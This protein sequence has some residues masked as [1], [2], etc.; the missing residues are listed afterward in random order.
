VTKRRHKESAKGTMIVL[1]IIALGAVAKFVVDYWPFFLILAIAC[2][3]YF[4]YRSARNPVRNH[5]RNAPAP[6]GVILS[7]FTDASH[8]GVPTISNG[9]GARSVLSNPVVASSHDVGSDEL[10]TFVSS[11]PTHASE[12]FSIPPAPAE[13]RTT[14]WVNISETLQIS[15]IQIS[16]A[17]LYVGPDLAA[18]SGR[19]DPALIDPRKP[20][21]GTG[22]YTERLTNY[23]PSYS[24]ISPHARR[25]YLEW[26]AEGRRAPD[27]DIGYVFLYF[28][29][30]EHRIIL[31]ILKDE[32]GLEEV[33]DIYDELKRLYAIYAEKSGSFKRYCGQLIEM[34]EVAASRSKL[35]EKPL[36]V[37]PSAW[38]FP[39][40]VRL[41]VGQAV[42]DGIPI[43]A[44]LALVWVEHDPAIVR[45]TAVTRCAAEFKKLFVSSY[46]AMYGDGLKITPNKTRLKLNY[47]PASSGFHGSGGVDLH[48]DDVPDIAALT[49]PSK[50]LQAL[51]DSCATLL[52]PYSR[53]L[54]KN[55]AG[56]SEL[57]GVLNLPVQLWPEAA[58]S[59][60]TVIKD[61]VGNSFLILTMTDLLATFKSTSS[62]G[63]GLQQAL[64]RVLEL[65]GIGMEPDL[66]GAMRANGSGDFVVLF[67]SATP[68]SEIRDIPAYKV[69]KLSVELA[70]AVAHA[71]GDFS[72]GELYHLNGC[73][74]RWEHLSDCARGRLK[75]YTR[76]LRASSI[77]LSSMRKN[78]ETLD[79]QSRESIAAFAATMVMADGGATPDEVKL[80]E[81][82]Y[83]QLGLERANLYSHIHSTQTP[84]SPAESIAGRTSGSEREAFSLDTAKIAMLKAS[85]DQIA[86]RLAA[87]F[88]DEIEPPPLP[89]DA[90]ADSVSTNTVLGLDEA[91]SA[92]ARV[93]M[94][95][96]TW[97]RSEMLDVAQDLEIMLDG[98]L[99]RL[100]ESCLDELDITFTEGDD[101]VHINP[102][103]MEKL[104]Q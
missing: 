7:G 67:K 5:P 102:D 44:N 54:A 77:G 15:G 93:L 103:L 59:A 62:L 31:D 72:K 53:Y 23:W 91:H 34:L 87:I 61:R 50:K 16:G 38:G 24:E 74:D 55:P 100:N 66:S 39:F 27:A 37:F 41:A 49:S 32:V 56:R 12:G 4:V 1:L 57:D 85:S 21:A 70:A 51:V 33:P 52:D 28:Y 19:T 94:S 101:P 82:I 84:K 13:L 65:E 2:A 30:L 63:K 78:L 60:L 104:T 83:Q 96:P 45:R 79:H 40:L 86:E 17:F 97:Q 80:L 47:E 8:V 76:L 18:P 90:Q 69:A 20:V 42:K 99:E 92:F 11:T 98:A 36:A 3:V 29:G 43:P 81:K 89:I 71:D 9:G 26:L 64:F 14:R 22:R 46:T 73:I 6:H 75:A 88:A 58:T 68:V 35:Y 95:R 10:R 25:A 48:F